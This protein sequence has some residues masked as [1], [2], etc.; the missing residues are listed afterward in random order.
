MASGGMIFFKKFQIL[1]KKFSFYFISFN[2][3]CF[4]CCSINLKRQSEHSGLRPDTSSLVLFAYSLFLCMT[5]VK[6]H[7]S[8]FS[9]LFGSPWYFNWFSLPFLLPVFLFGKPLTAVIRLFEF[10]ICFQ[11][12]KIISPSFSLIF[13]CEFKN[14]CTQLFQMSRITGTHSNRHAPCYQQNTDKKIDSLVCYSR[15]ISAKSGADKEFDAYRYL[16]E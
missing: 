10:S 7:E 4:Y 6:S 15:I 11:L 14:A 8:N 9:T 12:Q 1:E 5:F 13:T 2:F 16:I 3:L